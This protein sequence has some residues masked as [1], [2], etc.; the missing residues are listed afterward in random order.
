V[1]RKLQRKDNIIYLIENQITKKVYVGKTG[2]TAK[3]R[4]LKH[5]D[6]A[7]LRNQS[8]L[9][10]NSIRK[11]GRDVFTI[12]VLETCPESEANNRE[13]FYIAE[14]ESFTDRSK[15]YNLTAGGDGGATRTGQKCSEE[16]KAKVGLANKGRTWTPEQRIVLMEARRKQGDER[17]GVP[18]PE[19]K[20]RVSPNK[21]KK[22]SP[23]SLAKQL[24]T[25]LANGNMYEPGTRPVP[26][27]KP[28][29]K[30]RTPEE[31]IA[32]RADFSERNRKKQIEIMA[33]KPHSEE[34]RQ[35]MKEASLRYWAERRLA[36]GP[37]NNAGR[38]LAA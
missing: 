25:R 15:G 26:K 21:G 6:N 31:Q 5:L 13:I 1:P 22:M 7:T 36:G 33:T 32:F 2:W 23:E 35:K 18:R 29:S 34:A 20:G 16:H 19:L 10:Y 8:S 28:M 14:Y 9:L 30:R 37:M 11:H 24:A 17:R 12:S 27:W 38:A 3:R 4:L